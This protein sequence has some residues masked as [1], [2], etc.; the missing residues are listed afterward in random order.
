MAEGGGTI[1]RADDGSLYFIRDEILAACKVEGEY[2]DH[3]NAI[4]DAD[5]D[6]VGGFSFQTTSSFVQPVS[7]IRGDLLKQGGVDTQKLQEFS[8]SAASTIMCPW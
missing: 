2:L 3:V 8:N 7:Y 6:E 1:I 4:L 5:S